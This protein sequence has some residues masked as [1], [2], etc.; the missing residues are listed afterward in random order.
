LT[1]Y[2]KIKMTVSEDKQ[3]KSLLS[4]RGRTTYV[5]EVEMAKEITTPLDMHNEVDVSGLDQRVLDETKGAIWITNK[6]GEPRIKGVDANDPGVIRSRYSL[7]GDLVAGDGEIP[8][9]LNN[10]A[11]EDTPFFI[12][13]S[14]REAVLSWTHYRERF[15]DEIFNV[16]H[17]ICALPGV[18]IKTI[19][20]WIK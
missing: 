1:V 2:P 16:P 14:F 18:D 10:H 9:F 4:R 3:D 13:H 17:I 19:L 11:S 8:V 7:S 5:A 12:V 20:P 15:K 6:H